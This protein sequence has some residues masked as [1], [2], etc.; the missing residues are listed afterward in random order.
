MNDDQRI[1]YMRLDDIREADRNAK[2]H[3]L[4]EL[5]VAVD[6]LGFTTE[7]KVDERIGKL[8][9]GHGRLAY[10]RRLRDRGAKA[11]EGIRELDDDWAA[12]VVRGWASR[13]PEHG[14]AVQIADNA[15]GLGAGFNPEALAEQLDDIHSGAPELLRATTHTVDDLE[16]MLD[17]SS[18][19]PAGLGLSLGELDHDASPFTD[20]P[21]P[22]EG[23]DDEQWDVGRT[24]L[25][26]DEK[27]ARAPAEE[28]LGQLDVAPAW[29]TLQPW[30]AIY[31]EGGPAGAG[32]VISWLR[33]SATDVTVHAE[34]AVTWRSAAG[35][36]ILTAGRWVTRDG[37]TGHFETWSR[38]EFADRFVAANE[39]ARRVQRDAKPLPDQEVRPET[40]EA[41]RVDVERSLGVVSGAAT[42]LSVSD[43]IRHGSGVLTG[44]PREGT[45]DG[46]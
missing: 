24:V 42:V 9:R 5:G 35:I 13:S 40:A 2:L 33:G 3:D 23:D 45:G 34:H 6:A 14:E 39:P 38:E 10:L 11:P 17:Q 28:E 41:I 46:D 4:D 20:R 18:P 30:R 7:L 31:H 32:K 37:Q 43:L 21:T 1:E 26:E 29:R 22:A 12:P 19:A 16:R 8:V 25:D 36:E 15:V 27:P 44:R